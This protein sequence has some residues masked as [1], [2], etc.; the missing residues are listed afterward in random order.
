LHRYLVFEF[1]RGNT[2]S[3]LEMVAVS[4]AMIEDG[5]LDLSSQRIAI[6]GRNEGKREQRRDGE[7]AEDGG[8]E[9]REER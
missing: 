3:E 5:E 1:S 9:R 7:N 8:E 4:D 2:E 6:E